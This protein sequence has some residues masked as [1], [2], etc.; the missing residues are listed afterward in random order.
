[1][2]AFCHGDKKQGEV[3]CTLRKARDRVPECTFSRDRAPPGGPRRERQLRMDG[4][5]SLRLALA[6]RDQNGPTR[7]L[8]EKGRGPRARGEK[9][10]RAE[11][12]LRKE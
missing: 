4:E 10:S 1:M 12:I 9:R 11:Q 2:G 3:V 7:S 6:R 8:P 5:E